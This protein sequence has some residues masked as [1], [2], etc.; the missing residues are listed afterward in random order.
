MVNFF[1]CITSIRKYKSALDV[2]IESLPTEWKDKYIVV[3]NNEDTDNYKKFDDGHIEV[4]IKNNLSDYGN[5]LGINILLKDNIIPQDSWCLFVHD[6]CKFLNNSVQLT[7]KIIN[8]YNDKNVDVVWLCNTGQCNICLIRKKAIEH[9]AKIYKPIDCM[10]KKETIDYEWQHR[11]PLSPKSF[12]VNHV[13]INIPT[14]YLGKRYVYNNINSR[15][16][17]LYKSIDMEKYYV[18][19]EGPDHPMSP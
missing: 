6:T 1:V 19:T 18:K 16:V 15:E 7:N 12:P 11:H 5:W 13:R 17:L 14:I 8:D 9:G 2:I 4:Y 3:Y 10:T